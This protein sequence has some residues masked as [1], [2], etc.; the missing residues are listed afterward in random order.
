MIGDWNGDHFSDFLLLLLMLTT[1]RWQFHVV[2]VL[3]LGRRLLVR[4]KL[5]VQRGLLEMVIS[6]VGSSTRITVGLEETM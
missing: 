3:V 6:A 2:V 5:L 4:Y 1:G